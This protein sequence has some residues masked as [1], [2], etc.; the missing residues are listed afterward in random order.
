VNIAKLVADH[1]PPTFIEEAVRVVKDTGVR[2]ADNTN[3]R[4]QAV[5]FL[6]HGLHV[7]EHLGRVLVELAVFA[8]KHHGDTD[9]SPQS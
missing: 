7:P 3:R 2:L 6:Q 5:E 8:L 9:A 4:E 1:I